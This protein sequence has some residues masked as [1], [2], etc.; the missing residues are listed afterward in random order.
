MTRV[1][2]LLARVGKLEQAKAPA[3]SPFERDYGSVDA[4]AAAARADMD[5]GTLDPRDGPAVIAAVRRWHNDRV[6]DVWQ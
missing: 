3:L 4:F 5:T 2:S 6:W 1:R